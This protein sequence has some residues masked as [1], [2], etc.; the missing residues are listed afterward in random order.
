MITLSKSPT[1]N[2]KKVHCP[3]CGGRLCDVKENERICLDKDKISENGIIVKCYKCGNKINIS[4][5]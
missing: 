2:V 1:D 3:I 4:I 5:Y